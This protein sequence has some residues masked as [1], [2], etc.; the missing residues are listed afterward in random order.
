L[1]HR[2]GVR[3]VEEQLIQSSKNS[4]LSPN[5]ISPIPK[6][7]CHPHKLKSKTISISLP[8][9]MAT[10]TAMSNPHTYIAKPLTLKIRKAYAAKTID[11]MLLS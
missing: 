1:E 11:K 6:A 2:R 9:S 10:S 7:K 8:T 4:K 5:S 3:I